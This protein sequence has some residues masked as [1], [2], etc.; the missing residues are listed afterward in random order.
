M[1]SPSTGTIGSILEIDVQHAMSVVEALAVRGVG[2]A[3]SWWCGVGGVL[4]VPGLDRCVKLMV[5]GVE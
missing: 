3:W 4:M 2:G 1:F 5:R